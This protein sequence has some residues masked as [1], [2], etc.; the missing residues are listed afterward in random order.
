[1]TWVFSTELHEN[2]QANAKIETVALPPDSRPFW[3]TSSID[4]A[5][6][7][8]SHANPLPPPDAW[9]RNRPTDWVS[10]PSRKYLPDSSPPVQV[11]V[12]FTV[13]IPVRWLTVPLRSIVT[14]SE[15][16][17]GSSVIDRLRL[18]PFPISSKSKR[19]IVSVWPAVAENVTE[20]ATHA[21]A[22]N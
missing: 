1:M 14:S 16:G 3:P 5:S 15:G 21:W 22:V 12:P 11:I 7:V 20:P 18:P 13:A 6:A 8:P 10:W 2:M 9:I 17:G 4:H 19:K